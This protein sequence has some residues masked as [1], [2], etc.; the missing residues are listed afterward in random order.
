MQKA[1]VCPTGFRVYFVVS[2][3]LNYLLRAFRLSAFA[4]SVALQHHFQKQL[5]LL[6]YKICPCSSDYLLTIRPRTH[7]DKYVI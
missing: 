6:C 7:L 1:I 3:V 4:Q 2:L 5:M